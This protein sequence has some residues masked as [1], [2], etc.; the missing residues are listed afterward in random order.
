MLRLHSRRHAGGNDV[1]TTRMSDRDHESA[2]APIDLEQR[3]FAE[4][5]AE[6]GRSVEAI[7]T[8]ATAHL[9]HVVGRQRLKTDCSPRS[10]R[11]G[12]VAHDRQCAIFGS[13]APIELHAP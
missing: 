11:A 8:S 1:P 5:A 4:I 12:Q 2:A 6:P 7:A 9:A 13:N 3:P 10:V